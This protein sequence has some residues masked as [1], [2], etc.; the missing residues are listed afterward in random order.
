MLKLLGFSLRP[1]WRPGP[2]ATTR[3]GSHPSVTDTLNGLF[4]T[5]V[6]S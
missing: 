6:S 4:G 2:A 3:V 1:S 5:G